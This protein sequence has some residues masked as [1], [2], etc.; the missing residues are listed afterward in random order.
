MR[1]RDIEMSDYFDRLAL[2]RS[3]DLLGESVR[4]LTAEMLAG[5]QSGTDAVEAWLK[6]RAQ[7]V[8]RI[9][10]VDARDRRH[11][12]HAVQAGGGGEPARRSG[13]VMNVP[14]PACGQG[15]GHNVSVLK[16]RMPV[17]T[18]AMPASSA[19]LITSSSRIEPP[20]WI[21]AVAPASIATSRPSANGKKA[22]DATT[23]PL[24][25]GCSKPEFLRR[26][27]RLARG[28]ARRIDAAH[29]A[30]ADADGGEILRIDDGVGLD[31]LGDAEGEHQVAQFL[32]RRRAFGDRRAASCH[33]RPRCRG[34]APEAARRR[35]LTVRP[36]SARIGQ[37]A[38]EQQPQVLL[39]GDDCDRFF[40]RVRARRSLR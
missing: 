5:G 16:C 20:G 13:E 37:A 30:G 31:V 35:I 36:R 38:G 14:L 4:R 12:A 40:G 10:D 22:S 19:A 7:E 3:R 1:A 8:E 28:D 9:R 18:M 29:L 15:E 27:F 26:I 39:G 17:N 23:E 2:D 24:V 21:T 33:R 11:R 25:S 32:G 34:S 6:P